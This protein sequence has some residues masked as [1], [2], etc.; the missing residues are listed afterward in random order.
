MN[1]DYGQTL[2]D[3][4]FKASFGIAEFHSGPALHTD[5]IATV[6]TSHDS[7]RQRMTDRLW[8][9]RI[10]EKGEKKSARWFIPH[11]HLIAICNFDA[12]LEE[13][14]GYHKV[15][16]RKDGEPS[17]FECAQY[18]CG[19]REGPAHNH[20]SSA[21]KIFAILVMMNNVGLIFKFLRANIKDKHLPFKMNEDCSA[22]LSAIDPTMPPLMGFEDPWTVSAFYEKQW[23]FHIPYFAL[24]PQTNRASHYRLDPQTIFP[25]I[26]YPST[27]ESGGFGEV[28]RVRI[29]PD[30][31]GFV[32]SSL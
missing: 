22:L 12:V 5:N 24:D 3:S 7:A 10:P 21:R 32:S 6:T 9:A 11:R 1:V 4:N 8:A 15:Q 13:V 31:H 25:W 17:S 2:L 23:A 18:V 19:P 26:E 28:R 16:G 14:R 27:K 20:L 30:H 29:H